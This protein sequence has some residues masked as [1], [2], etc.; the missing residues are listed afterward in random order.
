MAEALRDR[1]VPS[2]LDRLTDNDPQGKVEARENRLLSIPQLRASVLRDLGWLFNATR[3]DAD[4]NLD[5]YPEIKR[6]VLNYGLPALSGHCVSGT[7]M[8][9]MERELRQAI[10]NFEPR[11]IADSITI[12]AQSDPKSL[13]HH[14]LISFKISAQLWAQPAPVELTLQTD[15]DLENGQCRIAEARASHQPK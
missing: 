3:L 8:R 7:D 13:N 14:N 5:A 9:E 2:L 11:L 15:I 6:S 1:L 4:G 12:K 10:I